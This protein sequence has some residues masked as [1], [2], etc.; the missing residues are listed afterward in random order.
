MPNLG[1]DADT[2]Y[3]LTAAASPDG[4]YHVRFIRRGHEY[5]RRRRQQAEEE[6]IDGVAHEGKGWASV[7]KK[8]T[9]YHS[10]TR[11]VGKGRKARWLLTRTGED[12]EM[13]LPRY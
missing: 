11:R 2:I 10:E 6:A 3:L 1:G 4:A 9:W 5:L 12:E 7:T 8:R 13:R